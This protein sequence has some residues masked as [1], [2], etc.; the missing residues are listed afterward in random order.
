MGRVEHN[1]LYMTDT[2]MVMS[3][4]TGMGN[5]SAA[6][7]KVGHLLFQ[8]LLSVFPILARYICPKLFHY[9]GWANICGYKWLFSISCQ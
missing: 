1:L 6:C 9:N 5:H 8:L 3:G 7:H 4:I 2:V